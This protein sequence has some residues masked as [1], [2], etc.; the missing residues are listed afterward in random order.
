MTIPI[1]QPGPD[2]RR[3]LRNVTF[4]RG[5]TEAEITFA[6]DADSDNDDGERVKLGFGALPT[7][8]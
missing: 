6:A 8:A 7:D 3:L 4:N 2:F 5:D 1:G